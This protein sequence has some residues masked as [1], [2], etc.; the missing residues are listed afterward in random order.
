M[1]ALLDTNVVVRHLM[2]DH[3]VQSPRAARLLH[4]MGE[5]VLP[6]VIFAEIVFVLESYYELSRSQ[7]AFLCWTVLALPSV[8][9]DQPQLLSR[10]LSIYVAAR[11]GFADAY[12]AAEAERDRQPVVSFDRDLDRVERLERIEP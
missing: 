6:H 12:I 1:T 9:T 7:V 11:I 3:P 8:V 5:L 4:S 10:A 2:E